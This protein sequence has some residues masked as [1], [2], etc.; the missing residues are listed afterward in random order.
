VDIAHEFTRLIV[1]QRSYQA[2]AR[3]ISVSD[4]LSQET[5]NMTR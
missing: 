4:E 1:M 3:V 5:I 2:N